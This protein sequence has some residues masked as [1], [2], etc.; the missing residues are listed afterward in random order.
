MRLL[1][2]AL[3]VLTT[4]RPG[5]WLG[6]ET[7]HFCIDPSMEQHRSIVTTAFWRWKDLISLP[8]GETQNCNAPRTI[9]YRLAKNM[10]GPALAFAP[11]PMFS[12][13]LAGEV[14]L[15]TWGAWDRQAEWTLAYLL[16]ETGHAFGLEES[17]M[18][19]D[20]T[21][22]HTISPYKL[23]PSQREQRWMRGAYDGIWN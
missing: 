12:E 16:H 8:A 19:E 13:P 7:V 22:P 21:C 1:L 17:C 4:A 11:A 14:L 2:T 23:F 20:L 18:E 6:R 15:D 9:T 5:P 3:F 10:S